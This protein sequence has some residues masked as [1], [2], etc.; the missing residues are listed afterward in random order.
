[1]DYDIV[2]FWWVC[3]SCLLLLAVAWTRG[4]FAA[5]GWV[6]VYLAILLVAVS[7]WWWEQPGPIDT[8]AA[9]LFLFVLLPAWIAK[10]CQRRFLQ[11]QYPAARRLAQIAAWLHP[12]DGWREQ[13]KIIRAL[14]LAKQ[15]DLAAAA[16][17]LKRFQNVKSVIGLAAVANLYWMANEWE[18]LLAWH[19]RQREEIERYPQLFSV[20]LRAR[21]ETGDIRGLVEFYDQRRQQIGKRIPATSRDTARL[22]LFAFC[23]QRQAVE[24]LFSGSLAAI[25]VSTQTFWLATAD[26]ATG[27]S[28]AAKRQL[29]E[30]LPAADPV[31]RGAIQRRLSRISTPPQPLDAA[32]ERVLEEVARE[33]G[34][35]ERFGARRSLFSNRARATQILILL[36]VVM[37]VAEVCL[38]GSTNLKVLYRLGAMFPP[39]VRAGQWWRLI[40][41]LFLHCGE[42]HLALN[43]FALWILGPFTEF[44]LGFRRFILVYLLAGIGSMA[45]VLVFGSGPD[46]E[47]LT[48]GASGCIM[49]LVGATGALMLRGWLRE[50]AFVAK[51]RLAAILVI[52][53]LQTLFDSVVPQVSMTA[54]L[55]GA[56]IGFAATMVLRDRI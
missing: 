5:R 9:I 11:Q 42:L 41:A 18:E 30:L 12:A 34:H 35:E 24:D 47:Q 17:A 55:S 44:A 31:L 39:A 7:G 21:G 38:G 8:A 4:R 27:A 48:V 36:N 51:R 53:V 29:E 10:L 20:V 3:L 54:H 1:M 46:G 13:P 45:V 56:F 25:P 22:M 37:F 2:L 49:G 14:E 23:G 43:M 50:K 28:E 16:D 15:G 19:A 26:L 40:A 6:A 52:V 32:A 33:H